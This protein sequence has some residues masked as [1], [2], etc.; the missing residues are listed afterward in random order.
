MLSQAPWCA[1]RLPWP[2]LP[3]VSLRIVDA[4]GQLLARGIEGELEVHAPCVTTGY[5][6]NELGN[7]EAF[8]SDGWFKT[9]DLALLNEE[10]RLH[11]TG[12]KKQILIV[13]GRNI[14]LGQIESTLVGLT[15]YGVESVTALVDSDE[16]DDREKLVL[17]VAAQTQ[18]HGNEKMN[19]L[20]AALKAETISHFG[21]SPSKIIVMP[22]EKYPVPQLARLIAKPFKPNSA[23][24]L[25]LTI[26]NLSARF[27]KQRA[28]QMLFLKQPTI[29]QKQR[30]LKRCQ[31]MQH[32]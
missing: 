16:H 25:C 19:D 29:Q 28:F 26:Q 32:S 13:N 1:S 21:V 5:H 11:I 3:D 8:T 18:Q 9:G 4:Q 24:V 2:P 23:R 15:G 30:V 20:C 14:S 12:R 10:G 6:L 17:V 7:T 27:P 31:L 22:M